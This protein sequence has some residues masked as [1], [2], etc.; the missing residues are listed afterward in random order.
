[1]DEIWLDRVLDIL[2]RLYPKAESDLV[3]NTPFELLVSAILSAQSTD[4]QVN[5][6]T[7]ELFK[8]YKP[9][10]FCKFKPKSWRKKYEAVDCIKIR[11]GILLKL[12]R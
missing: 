5:K 10:R 6:I 2:A 1:M 3:Y 11:A 8:K 7:A 9:G 4:K 12:L